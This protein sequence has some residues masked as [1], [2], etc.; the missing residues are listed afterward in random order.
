MCGFNTKQMAGMVR[1]EDGKSQCQPLLADQSADAVID[2]EEPNCLVITSK[3][4]SFAAT[5]YGGFAPRFVHHSTAM[6]LRAVDV[7]G[8][9]QAVTMTVIT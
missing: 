8:L 2:V 7:E 6:Q 5:F 3:T 4:S 9:Q 1:C